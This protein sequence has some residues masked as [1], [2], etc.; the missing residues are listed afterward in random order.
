VLA[1]RAVVRY[2]AG[3]L[4]ASLADLDRALALA[5]RNADLY[6]NRAVALADLG[7]SEDAARDLETYLR[8]QP[9]AEDRQEVE[10]RLQALT[11]GEVTA[12]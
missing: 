1:S 9:E 5:P 3:D 10:L 6:Q 2:A 4:A 12:P 7:R 11:A 8:L